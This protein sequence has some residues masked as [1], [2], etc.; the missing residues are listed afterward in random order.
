MVGSIS[1]LVVAHVWRR[2][3][4]PYIPGIMGRALEPC[5]HI[6]NRFG[7]RVCG[8]IDASQ[9]HGLEPP[10]SS[11]IRKQGVSP[12]MVPPEGG[13]AA[14]KIIIYNHSKVLAFILSIAGSCQY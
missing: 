12:S 8:G 6:V 2:A 10:S 4:T 14:A 11:S 13:R 1:A 5:L 9:P 7:R 3:G